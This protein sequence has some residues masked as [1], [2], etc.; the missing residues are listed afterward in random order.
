[1]I[2]EKSYNPNCCNQNMNSNIILSNQESDKVVILRGHVLW[3]NQGCQ[4]TCLTHMIDN[5]KVPIIWHVSKH[6]ENL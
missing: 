3:E 4:E 1:M 5:S 6:F 2:F